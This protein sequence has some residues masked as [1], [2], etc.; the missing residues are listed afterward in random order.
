MNC[1]CGKPVRTRG[2]C[3]A[4]Y[5]RKKRTGELLTQPRVVLSEDQRR[6]RKRQREKID[7]QNLR[8]R[9]KAQLVMACEICER[10]NDLVWDH[11][12]AVDPR[13]SKKARRGFRGTLCHRCNSI[14]G[15]AQDRVPL[16]RAAADY[17]ERKSSSAPL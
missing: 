6:I 12:H 11:D 4:C 17:L 5:L 9:K 13:R 1:P 2:L 10:L 14:L 15:F 16:L 8:T 7:R 3:M